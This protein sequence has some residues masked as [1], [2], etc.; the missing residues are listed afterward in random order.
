M[1]TKHFVARKNGGARNAFTL[2]ELLVVIAIIGVLA[3]LITGLA[4]PAAE[5]RQ[6][7]RVKVELEQLITAIDSYKEKKGFYPP[8]NADTNKTA[9]NQLFFELTGTVFDPT[10]N[11]Y[12]TIN[13]AEKIVVADI[14]AF[15]GAQGFANSS[16]ERGEVKNFIPALKSTQ[17]AELDVPKDVEILI[18]PVAGPNDVTPAGGKKINPWHYN[19]ISPTHNPGSYDLWAEIVTGDKTTIIGNWKE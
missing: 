5:K 14:N 6:I 3:A 2:I 19:S 15:F 9:I 13:G 4:K 18:V 1:N 8:S 7:S 17:F 12:Q 11:T 16:T 10:N